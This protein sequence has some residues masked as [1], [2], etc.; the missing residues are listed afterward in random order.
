[1]VPSNPVLL[2]DLFS[3][4]V[5]A[6]SDQLAAQQL[7]YV[8]YDMFVLVAGPRT[9][10]TASSKAGRQSMHFGG[11]TSTMSQSGWRRRLR[12]PAVHTAAIVA[13]AVLAAAEI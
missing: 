2:H 1:M 6:S 11:T 5:A 13:A 9:S 3:V 4:F 8:T 10:S 12:C 7:T